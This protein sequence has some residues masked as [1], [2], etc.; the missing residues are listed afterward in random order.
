MAPRWG[1]LRPE[2]YDPDSRDADGDGIVQ[3]ETAWERPVGTNLLDELGR[4]ITRGSSVGARPRGLR[5]V[6]SSGKDVDYTPTYQ[7]PGAAPGSERVGGTT[8]LADHGAGSLK[9]RGMPSVRAVAAPRV[10]E[11]EV[12]PEQITQADAPEA[13]ALRVDGR[14]KASA[15]EMAEASRIAK[16]IQE[17]V[18]AEFGPITTPR[19]V[20]DALKKAF[21]SASARDLIDSASRSEWD[22]NTEKVKALRNFTIGLL[23][24]SQQDPQTA[25][26]IN[27]LGNLHTSDPNAGGLHSLKGDLATGEFNIWSILINPFLNVNILDPETREKGEPWAYKMALSMKETGEFSDDEINQILQQSVAIHEFGHAMHVN[28]GLSHWGSDEGRAIPSEAMIQA[29]ADMKKISVSDANDEI[30]AHIEKNFTKPAPSDA[31]S[32]AITVMARQEPEG[33]QGL[34]SQ[35]MPIIKWDGVTKDEATRAK[36]L[37]DLGKVSEYARTGSV[38]EDSQYD[39]GVAE[40]I[41]VMVAT[42]TPASGGKETLAHVQS[43]FPGSAAASAD[44]SKPDTPSA[45]GPDRPREAAKHLLP[46]LNQKNEAKLGSFDEDGFGIPQVVPTDSERFPNWT[47]AVEFIEDGGDLMEVPDEYLYDAIV[48]AS[49]GGFP[50][51]GRNVE[52]RFEK[53]GDGEGVNGMLLLL[54]KT[55][56][57]KIG[58][59]QFNEKDEDLSEVLGAHFAERFGFSN[60]AMRIGRSL[61][62]PDKRVKRA[63]V[64]ELIQNYAGEPEYLDNNRTIG[65][66]PLVDLVSGTL[67]DFVISNSD[68]H[69]MNFF[70]VRDADGNNRFVP[71]DHSFSFGVGHRFEVGGFPHFTEGASPEVLA[72]WMKN[73]WSGE[74]SGLTGSVREYDVDSVAE[75]LQKV[76]DQLNV[77][78]ESKPLRNKVEEM[79]QLFS[80]PDRSL[81]AHELAIARFEWLASL[82]PAGIRDV[83]EALRASPYTDDPGTPEGDVRRPRD[84]IGWGGM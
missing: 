14:P 64:F 33:E 40:T 8:A 29:F 71:I 81:D 65:T 12:A 75:A 47:Y 59:K 70:I 77:D 1:G 48:K 16:S 17:S 80:D 36:I 55:T 31:I 6:D 60:G 23:H 56:G 28:A 13:P 5:V 83:A 53:L 20:E 52:P 43:I 54:D 57:K 26:R 39:E 78:R 76:V 18:E 66:A 58:L 19:Q 62:N 45:P 7:R 22:E 24:M 3:E 67:L 41:A 25:A 11:P 50:M 38:I 44:Q 15:K 32:R 84:D 82:D 69:H 72:E 4:A 46:R 51:R 63:M 21:P 42:G 73:P 68:R 74:R 35:L 27:V 2:P 49:E 30:N 79:L 9:E 37:E 61:N 10:P 34:I